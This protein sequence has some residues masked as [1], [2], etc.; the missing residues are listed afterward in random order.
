MGEVG[1]DNHRQL[2]E[3]SNR[4][5]GPAPCRLI[6][7]LAFPFFA[8]GVAVHASCGEKSAYDL[9]GMRGVA[10]EQVASDQ[11]IGSPAERVA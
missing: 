9:H 11:F 8:Y 6:N 4:A 10:V 7:H 1:G 5:V 2:N 3:A